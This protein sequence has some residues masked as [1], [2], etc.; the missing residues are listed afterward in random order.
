MFVALGKNIDRAVGGTNH[1]E[2]WRGLDDAEEAVRGPAAHDAPLA[3]SG[4]TIDIQ[5]RDT[6]W[7]YACP[8]AGDGDWWLVF[9]FDVDSGCITELNRISDSPEVVI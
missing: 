5:I 3:G 1:P 8:S 9:D 6:S 7:H 4:A 2:A